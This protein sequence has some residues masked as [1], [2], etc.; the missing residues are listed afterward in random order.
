MKQNDELNRRPPKLN[1]GAECRLIV[2]QDQPQECPYVAGAVARMP[3]RLPIGKLTIEMMESLLALGY[4]RSGDFVYRTQCPACSE[5]EPTRV[6]V[7]RFAWTTS[8]RRV[9]KR[10]DSALTM[11]VGPMQSD[12]ARVSL[13]NLHRLG[14]NLSRDEEPV[15]EDG[16]RSFL[17]ESCCD[18]VELSF[19]LADRLV[20][21]A[22]VDHAKHSLS[23]VYTYFDPSLSRYSLGTYAILKQFQ[24]ASQWGLTYL[25]LGMYVATNLHLN[26]KA[27]FLPQQRLIDGQ[28]YDFEK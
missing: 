23:A 10:G 20:A 27:R 12:Q 18:T 5:C 1:T 16:Y 24:R 4:R 7:D 9:M 26:Y 21:V 6:I 17:V 14:R 28:W 3:L 22:I 2:I 13:F 8:M 11:R 19:W 15:E 25:Y